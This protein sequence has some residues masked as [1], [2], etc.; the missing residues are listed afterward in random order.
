MISTPRATIELEYVGSD[1]KGKIEGGV[2][3]KK[4][5][6]CQEEGAE[7]K[8]ARKEDSFL[9]DLKGSEERRGGGL[10]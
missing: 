7:R 10:I 3:K 2:G 9:E 1:E 5:K 4:A 8:F 6:R